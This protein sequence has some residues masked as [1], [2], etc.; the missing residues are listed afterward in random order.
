MSNCIDEKIDRVYETSKNYT[1]RSLRG[2][3]IAI[4]LGNSEEAREHLRNARLKAHQFGDVVLRAYSL[5]SE[6]KFNA[7][8]TRA[9]S[10]SNRVKK[11]VRK[12]SEE[13]IR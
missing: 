4:T 8:R 13:R 9:I 12:N 6:E 2:Y 3:K 11:V 1:E 10:L 7:Q 5:L